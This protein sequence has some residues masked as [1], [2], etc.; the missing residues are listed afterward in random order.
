MSYFLILFV[1]IVTLYA[2]ALFILN[3]KREFA[4]GDRLYEPKM[5]FGYDF[6]DAWVVAWM[7]G[8]GEFE[9]AFEGEH[10]MLS[11]ILFILATFMI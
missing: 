1:I 11:Y 9:F 5:G 3:E 2:N 8:G 6:F 4:G 7:I 10:G